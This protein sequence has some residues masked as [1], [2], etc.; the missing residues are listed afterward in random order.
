[1]TT[2][3]ASETGIEGSSSGSG[4]RPHRG[5]GTRSF[6]ARLARFL[7]FVCIS[8]IAFG[9][10]VAVQGYI[11][12]SQKIPSVEKLKNYEPPIPT[13]IFADDG[14][15]IGEFGNQR[16]YVVTVEEVPRALQDALVA[17]D[18]WDYWK[19]ADADTKAIVDAAFNAF[20]PLASSRCFLSL[21]LSISEPCLCQKDLFMRRLKLALL[22]NRIKKALTREEIL[23][24]YMNQVYL[25]SGAYGVEAASR[26]YFGKSARDM[27]V[28]ECAMIAGLVKEPAR[29]SPNRNMAA[30]LDRRNHVLRRMCEYGKIKQEEYERAIREALPAVRKTPPRSKTVDDFLLNM[31]QYIEKVYGNDALYKGGLRVHTTVH[32][33]VTEAHLE[34][35]STPEIYIRRVIDRRG[36]VL[37][38]SLQ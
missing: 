29:Y 26:T 28:A 34:A 12:L 10:G 33:P 11:F 13:Q 17:A 9:M 15:L 22:F 35:I 37:Q 20:K 7:L 36:R 19:P 25:G 21:A 5:A 23:Y 2:S 14:E 8:C 32:L 38:E 6:L 16:R 27:T 30:A 3:Q 31:R 24:I 18:G 4:G 1:M